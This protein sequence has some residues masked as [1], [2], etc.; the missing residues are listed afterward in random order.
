MNFIILESHHL[1][2]AVKVCKETGKKPFEVA[3]ESPS[4]GKVWINYN[5][6]KKYRILIAQ[7]VEYLRCVK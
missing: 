2:Q 4:T 6:K 1:P 3:R 7:D 5:Y